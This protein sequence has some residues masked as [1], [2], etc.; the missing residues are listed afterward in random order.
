VVAGDLAKVTPQLKA[1]PELRNA[2]FETVRP[3]Q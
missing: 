3:F 2:K 1:L